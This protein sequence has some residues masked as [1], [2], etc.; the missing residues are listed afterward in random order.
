MGFTPGPWSVG[1][2][3]VV[4]AVSESDSGARV[5]RFVAEAVLSA[6]LVDGEREANARLIAA[7]PDLYEALCM[8]RDA[9]EDCK[10]D[11]LPTIP[12]IARAKI[13]RAIAKAER[14]R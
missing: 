14:G 4:R 2:Q 1:P 5:T 8:V 9:D 11:G 10:R 7:A 12:D 6:P 3:H 13:D